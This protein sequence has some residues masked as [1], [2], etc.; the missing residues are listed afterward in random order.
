MSKV[1][2]SE[3][4]FVIFQLFLLSIKRS[5]GSFAPKT[6][7]SRLY[8]L[9]I[10]SGCHFEKLPLCT[11]CDGPYDQQDYVQNVLLLQYKLKKKLCSK[12]SF[13]LNDKIVKK[14]CKKTYVQ[15]YAFIR[16]CRFLST[17]LPVKTFCHFLLL[18]ASNKMF[19]GPPILANPDMNVYTYTDVN[20][21]GTACG[22]IVYSF[23]ILPVHFIN[24]LIKS[25][26]FQL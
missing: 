4:L 14:S 8:L 5:S 19:D 12:F 26:L 24:L 17:V 13:D 1:P 21:N 3:V 2:Y 6:T 25:P 20:I 7:N 15:N 18:H 11:I 9:F 22:H 10:K 23:L 16:I